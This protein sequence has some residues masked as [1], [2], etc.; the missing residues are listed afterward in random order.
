MRTAL[1]KKGALKGVQAQLRIFSQPSL[2]FPLPLFL[3]W[4]LDSKEMV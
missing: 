3:L 1:S 4:L 2:M